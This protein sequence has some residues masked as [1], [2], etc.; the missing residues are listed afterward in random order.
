MIRGGKTLFSEIIHP[1]MREKNTNREREREVMVM[2]LRSVVRPPG[3]VLRR[4]RRDGLA[5]EQHTL[6]ASL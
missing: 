6:E 2:L 1:D 3:I 5:N 4:N